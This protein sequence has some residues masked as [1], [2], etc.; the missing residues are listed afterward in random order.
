MKFTGK[1]N[2]GRLLI[3]FFRDDV[4]RSE[5]QSARITKLGPT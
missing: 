1:G 2:T 3:H 4:L 5:A